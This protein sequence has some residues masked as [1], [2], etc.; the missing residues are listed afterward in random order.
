MGTDEKEEQKFPVVGIGAS[1]GGLA[2]FEAFFTGMSKDKEPNMTFV[3]IQHLAPDHKSILT[4]I[5]E[6]YTNLPVFEVEDGMLIKPNCIYI[7]PPKKN[8]ALINGSLQLLEITSP[9]GQNLPID[10]FF[11]SLAIDQKE[12]A[13]C[14][15]LSGTGSDGTLGLRAIKD[16]GGIAIA[17]STESAEYAGMP[18]SAIATGLVDYQLAPSEMIK[19]LVSYVSHASWIADHPVDTQELNN[20]NLLKKIFLLI[21]NQRGHDFSKYKP[22]MINRR[23]ERRLAVNQIENMTDYVKFLQQTPAEIEV[24]LKDMLIGVTSFFRDKDAFEK[25]EK[26]IIRSFLKAKLKIQR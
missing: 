4:E 24:L 1:A 7:I 11:R 15:V 22:S 12:R 10:Y 25:L 16:E 5:I 19:N 6:R 14:I 2:A 9:R 18:S 23:I 13:I 17:Q 20:E 3:L 21:R 26:E 8:M